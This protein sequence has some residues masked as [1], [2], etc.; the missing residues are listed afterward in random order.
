M[1][2]ILYIL[3]VALMVLLASCSSSRNYAQSYYEPSYHDE[4]TYQQF[5]DDLSPYGN[6]IMYPGYGYVW[7]PYEAGFHPYQSNGRWAFTQ[8]G[9]MWVSNYRW[10]WAPFHY[11]RWLRDMRY[12]WLWVPGYEWA[13]AWVAWRGGGGYYG[14]APL[15]PGMSINISFGAIPHN[16][17]CFVPSRYIN[18]YRM[19]RYY[20]RPSRNV[21]I[22]N[23]TTIINNYYDGRGENNRYNNDD[24]RNRRGTYNA[25]PRI[26]DVER[27]TNQKIAPVRVVNRTSPGNPQVGRNEIAVYRPAVKETP[28]TVQPRRFEN[29]PFRN[30]RTEPQANGSQFQNN[31]I[32]QPRREMQKREN[33]TRNIDNKRVFERK[34]NTPEIQ[35]QPQLPEEKPVQ[36]EQP[37]VEPQQ[38][39]QPI[40]RF[41]PVDD[42]ITERPEKIERKVRESPAQNE[43]RIFR[44][45]QPQ[46]MPEQRKTS[47]V[48]RQPRVEK[49]T[50]QRPQKSEEPIRTNK[51]TFG[52]R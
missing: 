10:G 30:E 40:R 42:R 22:I 26:M 11:G 50:P 18:N 49:P 15:G 2:K 35:S 48:I 43:R 9:W 41:T 39:Q 34:N 28:T 33:Q 6:W 24:Y 44:N 19:D 37:R 46:Q 13:P 4:V 7:S 20:V 12:G 23:N 31:G 47:P 38:R 3:P 45:N 52:N 25:G 14:W 27:Q 8:M 5:Y 1:K 32:D 17:W 51:R 29:A 16:N 36:Y 21:T